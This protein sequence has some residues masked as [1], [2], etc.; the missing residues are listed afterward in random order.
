MRLQRLFRMMPAEIAYR[1][2]QEAY[3]TITRLGASVSNE[4]Y[5]VPVVFDY[6]KPD[7]GCQD[8][9]RLY[10]SSQLE[11]ASEALLARF[12]LQGPPRFFHGASDELIPELIAREFPEIRDRIIDSADAICRGQFSILGYGRL[13]YG[14]PIDWHFDPVSGVRAP[15]LHWSRIHALD[16]DQVGDSKVIWEV[17]RHQW[18]LDLGQAYRLTGDEHYAREFSQNL[19]SWMQANPAGI[20]INWS[21]SLEVAIR[22]M[23]WSWALL[24]FRD[25]AALTPALFTEI[26]G[27]LRVHANYVERYLS[28]YFSPN[29]HLTGEALGLFYAGTL[30]PELQ[31]A[32]RWRGLASRILEEQAVRQIHEDGVYFEQSTRYQYYTVDI[33]LH[34]VLLAKRNGIAV[35]ETTMT[36]LQRM[37]DF[38][39]ALRRPDGSLPQIGD[40]DGGWLLPMVRRSSDDYSPLF[41]VAA[42]LF[43]RADLAWAAGTFT[44]E[45]HWLTGLGGREQFQ[46]LKAAPPAT[47]GID[48]FETGGYVVMRSGWG[49]KDHQLILDAGP[50]G[51]SASGGHGHA[52]LLSVQ[53]SAFGENY[54]VDA[55]TGSYVANSEWRNYFRSS[56]AHSTVMIDNLSQAQPSGPFSWQER[57]AAHLE[58]SKDDSLQYADASHDAWAYL[59][60]PVSHR[61]RVLFVDNSYWVIVDELHGQARHKIDLRF[62]F[63]PLHVSCE[64]SSWVRARGR[65]GHGLLLRSFSTVELETDIKAGALSPPQG[66]VS[67][68]YGHRMSAPAVSQTATALL[69]LRIVT[70][71]FPIEDANAEPPGVTVMVDRGT[72][73][74]LKLSVAQ[75]QNGA[76]PERSI[77]IDEHRIMV[78]DGS[79]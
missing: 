79:P 75:G 36:Q 16:P 65:R 25:S 68:N 41:S 5:R 17:N 61:R 67:P 32:E 63:A 22:M 37:M 50:L 76:H 73:T 10:K 62:Q 18:M 58:K 23:S 70:V 26:M 28:Y 15:R 39:L 49:S 72:V 34:Y 12:R 7:Q 3:K 31:G 59:D 14:N 38:L 27:W 4:G 19:R 64:S 35:S 2:W 30:F 69:P 1:G 33:Y 13:S 24:L 51:C 48:R 56:C 43:N 60:D 9:I 53:C 29:T 66:W 71:L 40:A 74:G 47:R 54:L 52:D 45:A 42:T 44:P 46:Q 55:G 57:P 21:S 11:R 77:M 20:G 78:E 8:I 6:L